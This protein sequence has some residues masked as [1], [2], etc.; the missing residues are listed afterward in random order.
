[1]V[2]NLSAL[3]C[4]L[5]G[6]QACIAGHVGMHTFACSARS[7][8]LRRAEI[9]QVL[10]G[11]VVTVVMTSADLLQMKSIFKRWLDYE[12]EHGTSEK[13]KAVQ[14]AARTYVEQHMDG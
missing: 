8:Q 11:H 13:A 2:R 7:L 3:L 6:A 14:D 5:H 12:M 4:H 9:G 1:M 10:A